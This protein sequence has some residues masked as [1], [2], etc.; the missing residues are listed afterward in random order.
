MSALSLTPAKATNG[1]GI[2]LLTTSR[3]TTSRHSPIR[4]RVPSLS[5]R[6]NV[7]RASTAKA[8]LKVRS[9]KAA[10]NTAYLDA[11]LSGDG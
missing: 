5:S 4:A 1:P 3:L 7:L 9:K 11:V 6:L 10:W 2:A 8:S